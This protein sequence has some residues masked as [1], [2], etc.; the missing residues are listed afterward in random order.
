MRC[1]PFCYLHCFIIIYIFPPH[2]SL[3]FCTS[4]KKKRNF[5]FS[6]LLINIFFIIW[7]LWP[8]FI[9]IFYILNFP[10]FF[11]IIY[12][13]LLFCF[14]LLQKEKRKFTVKKGQKIQINCWWVF[15]IFLLRSDEGNFQFVFFVNIVLR[16]RIFIWKKGERK[17]EHRYSELTISV[18]FTEYCERI[19]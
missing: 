16:E 18:N 17:N 2:F 8:F 9:T 5:Q 6:S 15:C 11:L 14:N 1:F 12:F 4:Q 10:Q 3:F 19:K 7:I 13:Y